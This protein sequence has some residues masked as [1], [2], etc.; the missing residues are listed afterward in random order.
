MRHKRKWGFINKEGD[1]VIP[2]KWREVITL[3][4]GLHRPCYFE[5]GTIWVHDYWLNEF[6]IDKQGN[7]LEKR[8]GFWSRRDP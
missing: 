8:K 2:Y 5:D 4:D 7:I 1:I 3:V 6:R